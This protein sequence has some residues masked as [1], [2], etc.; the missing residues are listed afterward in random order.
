MRALAALGLA[1]LLTI[2]T[3]TFAADHQVLMLNKDTD[4]RP[5]QFEPAFLKV[6]PGDTVTFIAQDKGHNTEAIAGKLP[7]GAVTWKGKINEEITV[8][9][10]VAGFYAY[11]CLPHYS[12]GMVGLI[13][14]G[15]PGAPDATLADGAPGKGKTRLL[16]LIAEAQEQ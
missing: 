6:E 2:P 1:A 10:D 4:G 13:Q 3:A 8:T 15:T 14:V 5:M 7:D 11:K 16:E 12:L 9:F